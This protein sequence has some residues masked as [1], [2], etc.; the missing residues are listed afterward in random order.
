[1]EL[2][3]GLQRGLQ[4]HSWPGKSV[5][6]KDLRRDVGVE[7]LLSLKPKEGPGLLERFLGT[8]SDAKLNRGSFQLVLSWQGHRLKGFVWKRGANTVCEIESSVNMARRALPVFI[9]SRSSMIHSS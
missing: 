9:R 4:S 6:D 3:R 2:D 8:P 5:C 7:G 1:M